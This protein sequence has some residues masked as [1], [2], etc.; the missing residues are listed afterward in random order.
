MGTFDD[1]K[2]RSTAG[3]G[4][5]IH[6]AAQKHPAAQTVPGYDPATGP[7]IALPAGEHRRIP[8][9]TGDYNGTPRDLLAK[10]IRD[11]RN[12]TNGPNGSLQELIQLNKGRYPAF[13]K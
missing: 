10:D 4:L 12:N 5:D 9:I 1:L 7:A 13:E 2:G 11:L 8:T 6:H 3:D